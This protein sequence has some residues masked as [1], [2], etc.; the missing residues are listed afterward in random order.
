MENLIGGINYNIFSEET[1]IGELLANSGEF[2]SYYESRRNNIKR[3][4]YWALDSSLDTGIEAIARRHE[5]GEQIILLRRIPA[6]VTDAFIIAHELEHL[7]MDYEGFFSI[8][9]KVG[10]EAETLALVFNG[11]I[12]DPI[13]NSRLELFGFDLRKNYDQLSERAQEAFK[14]LREPSPD[15]IMR[16][17]WTF[18]NV[19]FMLAYNVAY[20]TWPDKRWIKTMKKSRYPELTKDVR[21]LT[22]YIL[23]RGFDTP[24]KQRKL[25]SKIIDKYLLGELLALH[26]FNESVYSDI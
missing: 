25:L 22:Q 15:R 6:Q 3:T 10:Y 23:E 26:N 13:I 8:K 18:Q 19:A 20:Q 2:K 24:E 7:V 14:N 16:L 1:V 9:S 5:T 21:E 12:Q 4:V 11:M 17:E